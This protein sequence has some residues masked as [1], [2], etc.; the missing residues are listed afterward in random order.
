MST[1]EKIAAGKARAFAD[2]WK[3]EG[4]SWVRRKGGI[5]ET[6]SASAYPFGPP[7]DEPIR[8]RKSRP[9]YGGIPSSSALVP[10]PSQPR[11]GKTMLTAKASGTVYVDGETVNIRAGL[12]RV[13]AGHAIV[14]AAP[15]LFGL[16][17]NG[18]TPAR[19]A[20]PTSVRAPETQPWRLPEPS[21]DD[22][23]WRLGPPRKAPRAGTWAEHEWKRS[24]K[25]EAAHAAAAHI[26]GWQVGKV[27]INPNGGGAAAAIY[28]PVGRTGERRANELALI[29]AV[30]EKYCGWTANR[31][32][33]NGDRRMVHEASRRAPS[34]R[35]AA[36]YKHDL[37]QRAAALVASDR[38]RA[39]ARSVTTAV[40]EADGV[41]KGEALQRAL[42]AR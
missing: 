30:A 10:H 42:R 20:A 29:A 17:S 35:A 27:E 1:A 13:E 32:S 22:G 34:D 39:I 40:L 23:S 25:H 37:Y 33:Y 11:P 12:D 6:V 36:A 26:L 19:S 24:A 14:K 38:F 31:N 15:H 18:A 4:G 41:L 28:S 9:P 16:P 5:T 8:S 3:L 7:E 21:P 2:G